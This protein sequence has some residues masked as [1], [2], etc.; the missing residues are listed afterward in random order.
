MS[1]PKEILNKAVSDYLEDKFST[2][3]FKYSDNSTKFTKKNE[4]GFTYE[5]NF[6]G[7]KTNWLD[8]FVNFNVQYL[9]YSAKYKSWHKKTFPNQAILGGGYL[10]G[11]R[12]IPFEESQVNQHGFG[13]DFVK[14]EPQ[15]IMEEIWNNYLNHGRRY[16]ESGSTW[17]GVHEHATIPN[18]KIDSLIF[19]LTNILYL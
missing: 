14:F 16:F 10:Q 12:L 17:I 2:E 18:L 9:I 4:V 3:G 1:I 19:L 5:I 6:L 8:E 7:S 11:N 13:Y 15:S